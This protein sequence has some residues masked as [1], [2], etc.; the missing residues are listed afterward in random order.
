MQPAL[1]KAWPPDGHDDANTGYLAIDQWGNPARSARW[2]PPH[3]VTESLA[4][5]PCAPI[6]DNAAL[7]LT[8]VDTP[9]LRARSVTMVSFSS[10]SSRLQDTDH[11]GEMPALRY[12]VPEDSPNTT[13]ATRQ[14][15][16]DDDMTIQAE[17]PEQTT[18]RA[19]AKSACCSTAPS[20]SYHTI[21][22]APSP[23]P[24]PC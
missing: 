13:G 20:S 14:L 16:D 4:P 19:G 11:P 18:Y 23:P 15:L 21:R 5:K 9:D 7:A 6:I 2:A 3:A 8:V 22:C 17:A 1:A 24:T 10:L 12:D